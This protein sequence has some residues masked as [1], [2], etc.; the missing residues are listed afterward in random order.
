[1]GVKPAETSDL[2]E[3]VLIVLVLEDMAFVEEEFCEEEAETPHVD[4]RAVGGDAVDDFWGLV[5]LG[6]EVVGLQLSH[7]LGQSEV[8]ETRS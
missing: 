7:W 8:E 1:L 3:H 6:A 2:A 4:S 5:A